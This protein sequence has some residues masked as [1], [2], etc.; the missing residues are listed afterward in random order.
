MSLAACSGS[1]SSA[2][3][4][5][6]AASLQQALARVADTDDTRSQIY[7]DDTSALVKLAGKSLDDTAGF[8]QLRGNGATGLQPLAQTI[9]SQPGIELLAADYTITAGSPPRQVGLLAGGQPGSSITGNLTRVGWRQQGNTLVGPSPLAA[10]GDQQD[11]AILALNLAR[12]RANGADLTYGQTSANLDQIGSP[13]GRTLAQDPAVDAAAECLGDV[14]AAAIMAPYQGGRNPTVLA[15]GIRRPAS[16]TDTPPAVVCVGW[17]DQDAAS[18]YATAV[19]QQL[20][21]GLSITTNSRYNTLLRTPTVQNVGGDQHLVRWQADTPGDAQRVFTMID[22]VD[23]P[24][25]PN[26]TELGR[27]SAA[28]RQQFGATC[29]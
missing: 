6:S 7:Y 26:C 24:A 25:L 10:G 14:V 11:T 20:T 5:F 23:L 28:A 15:A 29:P 2:P 9:A 1:S 22:S 8:A 3:S 16:N 4:V 18:A 12:V 17:P 19:R 13:S 21:S 27:L